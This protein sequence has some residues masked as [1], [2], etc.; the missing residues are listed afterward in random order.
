M[1]TLYTPRLLHQ[2]PFAYQCTRTRGNS[3]TMPFPSMFDII[4]TFVFFSC[5]AV[6][7]SI[8]YHLLVIM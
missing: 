8:Q 1:L 5:L 6:H 2:A 4:R 3:P 7:P